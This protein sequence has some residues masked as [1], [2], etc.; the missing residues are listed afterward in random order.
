MTS[1]VVQVH[2]EDTKVCSKL[3]SRGKDGSSIASC[4]ALP[5]GARSSSIGEGSVPRENGLDEEDVPGRVE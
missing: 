2:N 5:D 4:K 1:R 3:S